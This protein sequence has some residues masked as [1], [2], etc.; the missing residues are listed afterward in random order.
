MLF[1]KRAFVASICSSRLSASGGAGVGRQVVE[2]RLLVGGTEPRDATLREE[3][4][5]AVHLDTPHLG[6][7]RPRGVD[8]MARAAARREHA[9]AKGIGAGQRRAAAATGGEE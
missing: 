6:G 5:H 8:A 3:S 1:A 4:A 9:G 7:H 2:H